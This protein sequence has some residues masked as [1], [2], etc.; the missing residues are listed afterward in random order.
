MDG[1]EHHGRPQRS[2]EGLLLPAQPGP[3]HGGGGQQQ[4]TAK[5]AKADGSR[6]HQGLDIVVVDIL[7]G[8]IEVLNAVHVVLEAAQTQAQNG[9]LAE[10]LHAVLEKDQTLDGVLVG[11]QALHTVGD[12]AGQQLIA[13]GHGAGTGLA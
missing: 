10:Q 1:H 3:D 12:E 6:V 13:Q 5:A 7:G 9:A 8:V 4:L 11:T 2:D